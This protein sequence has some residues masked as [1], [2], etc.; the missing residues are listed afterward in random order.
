M[1][2]EEEGAAFSFSAGF[3]DPSTSTYMAFLKEA[4]QRAEEFL[5]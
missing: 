4:L 2:P 3:E 1:K 5:Q